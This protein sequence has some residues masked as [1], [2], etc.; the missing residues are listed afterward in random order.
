MLS[1]HIMKEDKILFPAAENAIPYARL[2]SL[3]REFRDFDAEDMGAGAIERLQALAEKLT[4]EFPPDTAAL[5][6]VRGSMPRGH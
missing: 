5:E 6:A 1:A 4:A 2:E 3:D